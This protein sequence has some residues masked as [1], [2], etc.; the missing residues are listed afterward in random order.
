[1]GGTP[2]PKEATS[3]FSRLFWPKTSNPSATVSRTS[4]MSQPGGVSA[5]NEL[6]METTESFA[7]SDSAFVSSSAPEG[8]SMDSP[9]VTTSDATPM[10]VHDGDF[11]TES[12]DSSD[13]MGS[14][15]TEDEEDY[16]DYC[17]GGYHPVSVGDVFSNGRY[18]I[19]RKLGWGHFSTVWL[20]KDRVANRHVALKVVKSAPH[21][22]ETALD[23]IK[24]LQ[25]L[26][27][28]NQNHP[29]CRHCVSLL[30]HFRHKGPNGSHVCMVFEVLGE[31]LLGLIKRYQHRGVPVH[32]VKQIAKQVLLGL[33]YM[34][35]SCG[36][37]H[38]DLKPENVLICIED[39]E[40]V[41]EA[42][43]QTNPKAVPT[44]LV[45]VPPSQGRGGAQTPRRDSVLITSS[46]PLPSP[47]SSLGT[48]PMFDKLAFAMSK[49]GT[50]SASGSAPSE[51]SLPSPGAGSS[52]FPPN[53]REPASASSSLLGNKVALPM[54][55]G[56]SL[57]SQQANK[58]ALNKVPE[59]LPTIDTTTPS[60]V[61][62][63]SDTCLGAAVELGQAA[64]VSSHS[65]PLGISPDPLRP[66]PAA[67]DPTTLP[68][69]PPYDPSTLERITVK[70][71]DLGNACWTDHHF[72]NDIQTRQYR[73]PEAILGAKWG[74]TAD[75]WSASAMFFELLTGD[76][77]F[78]PAAGAKYNKDD[79]HI[80]QII[81]L[82]GD[83]PKSVAFSGKYSAEIFNRKG[84]PRH[85]HK[86]RYWPLVNVLQEKYLLTQEHSEELSSFLLPMLRLNPAERAS[87]REALSHPWLEGVITQGEME[88]A[89]EQQLRA[90][91]QGVHVPTRHELDVEDA[92][93]PIGSMASSPVPS[94]GGWPVDA[95]GDTT[96]LQSQLSSTRISPGGANGSEE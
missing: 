48:S 49:I 22:T 12:V 4:A 63:T 14:V 54:R 94:E 44:K 60:A 38:T 24:L 11:M 90:S 65:P 87:A 66:A 37:I 93:K 19:V 80:A 91:E 85:I 8:P 30:D 21:Y 52:L 3:S 61:E 18:V 69:P 28:A 57:L 42:E 58:G 39:V 89:L 23:E 41:V 56:P 32:I 73:C 1:M 29:G 7:V 50:T 82:L 26:V 36:I 15:L 17:R 96:L 16:E 47:S 64:A 2:P 59:P 75:L 25:R 68:P 10:E 5:P 45:G 34:H 6:T 81:E 77:L 43:L 95:S 55:K 33:D 78:D 53:A 40:A 92:L 9:D 76:Y 72:T 83:F 74:T 79:D 51:S 70:I 31:N 27:S 20:A 46:R 88:L 86:L 71:A 35:R 84:E 67:G 62:S 13:D